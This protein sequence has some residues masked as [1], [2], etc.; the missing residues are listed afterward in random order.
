M[1][2]DVKTLTAET[3]DDGFVGGHGGISH[4]GLISPAARAFGTGSRHDHRAVRLHHQRRM[5]EG[6][7]RL[8]EVD[9]LGMAA[10][11]DDHEVER[12]GHLDQEDLPDDRDAGL[13]HRHRVAGQDVDDLSLL[14]EHSVER[15][16]HAHDPPDLFH[17]LPAGVVLVASDL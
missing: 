3:L 1:R 12:L 7:L 8:V 16:V 14:I 10:G 13:H 9:V 5:A 15:I 11:R 6:L 17:V 2:A 4:P